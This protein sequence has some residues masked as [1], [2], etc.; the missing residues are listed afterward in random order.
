MEIG[1]CTAQR[2][3][4]C[5]RIKREESGGLSDAFIGVLG[6]YRPEDDVICIGAEWFLI[7]WNDMWK[8]GIS[9][10]AALDTLVKALC[11]EAD[12]KAI[13]DVTKSKNACLAFDYLFTGLSKHWKEN[14]E[15]FV[16][17]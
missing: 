17:A 6:C 14:R 3:K 4:W 15:Y 9:K 5:R 2:K 13:F 16:R 1:F 12:H 11:H 10:E 8:Q 7:D